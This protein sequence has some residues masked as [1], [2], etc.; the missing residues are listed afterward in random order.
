MVLILELVKLIGQE[1][2]EELEVIKL[3]LRILL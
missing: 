1:E 2:E 3:T